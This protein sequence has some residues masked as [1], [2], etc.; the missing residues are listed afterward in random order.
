MNINEIYLPK[1]NEPKEIFRTFITLYYYLL[2]N[3]RLKNANISFCDKIMSHLFKE[4]SKIYSNFF[5][6]NYIRSQN[7]LLF[8]LYNQIPID[9]LRYPK[10]EFYFKY[11]IISFSSTKEKYS[12]KKFIDTKKIINMDS[13][14][15]NLVEG[16]NMNKV[17]KTLNKLKESQSNNYDDFQPV[18]P[19]KNIFSLNNFND[20]VLFLYIDTPIISKKYKINNNSITLEDYY[21]KINNY[22]YLKK[23]TRLEINE[24]QIKYAS[25][26]ENITK[27]NFLKCFELKTLKK[28]TYLYH[29]KDPKWID[30]S[31]NENKKYIYQFYTLTPISRISD[32]LYF[33]K[34][35]NY[36]TR[37]Y[38]TT[39]NIE[40]LD[41][42]TNIY[43]NNE[44]TKKIY[45]N[46]LKNIIFPCFDK[47]TIYKKSKLCDY[48]L[49][50]PTKNVRE[51][52]YNRKEALLLII[53]KNNKYVD[54]EI[55]FKKFLEKLGVKA[56]FNIMS[57][58]ELKDSSIKV[59]GEEIFISQ[60]IA[61]S[62]IKPS[63]YYTN[64]ISDFHF[65]N[66]EYK[67]FYF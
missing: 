42:S 21:I 47:E 25:F 39:N 55:S 50:N 35:S 34:N 45:K 10:E 32:P 6:E 20:K 60:K 66:K 38:I 56:Y 18:L 44:I 22:K 43:L 40:I 31:N 13:Y 16:Y 51:I 36:I 7:V 67:N 57:L 48:N 5:H 53:W 3:D 58:V 26:L 27:D 30:F 24:S 19:I 46:D 41:I 2:L 62:S 49:V 14:W 4:N 17:K 59:L 65:S 12:N 29:Q 28:D 23:N 33:E 54:K 64:K 1:K 8:T 61:E 63:V 11:P 9:F 37:E 15:E 52:N